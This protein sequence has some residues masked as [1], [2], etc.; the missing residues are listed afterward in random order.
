MNLISSPAR[1]ERG[2]KRNVPRVG[3]SIVVQGEL[4]GTEDLTIDG[5]VEGTITLERHALTIGTH[6]RVRA[7]VFARSIVVQGEVVGNL[8]ATERIAIGEKGTV[9]GDIKA[10]RVA[11][12]DGAKFR[13]RIDMQPGEQAGGS[14]SAQSSAPR[15][16]KPPA[17]RESA[18]P[19]GAKRRPASHSK[20]LISA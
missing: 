7:Q 20:T 10:P 4:C 9:D 8:E 19:A 15:E 13:G 14:G 17:G 1:G 5:E 16:E 6:G 3:R 11:I 2:V 18:Q 12:A